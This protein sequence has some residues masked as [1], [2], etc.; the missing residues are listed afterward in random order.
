MTA[1]APRLAGVS[2]GVLRAVAERYGLADLAAE[3][4]LAGGFANDVVL[5]R[6]GPE[7]LVRRIK[8]PPVVEESLAWEHA[9]VSALARALPEV[10]APLA[11]RD[12]RTFFVEGERAVSLLP[13]VRGGAA[14]AAH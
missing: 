9:V 1:T 7:R 10:P 12:G 11:A 6:A 8:H 2:D 13:F 14:G 5:V 3:R 4:P